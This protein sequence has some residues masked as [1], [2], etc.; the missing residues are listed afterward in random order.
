M[1]KSQE[2]DGKMNCLSTEW[3]REVYEAMY[4]DVARCMSDLKWKSDTVDK[5]LKDIVILAANARTHLDFDQDE[6]KAKTECCNVFSDYLMFCACI[7]LD[8]EGMIN[9]DVF[10]GPCGDFFKRAFRNAKVRV[11][12]LSDDLVCWPDV[13]HR[14]TLDLMSE[15]IRIHEEVIW[16]GNTVENVYML[17]DRIFDFLAYMFGNV[18]DFVSA[19]DKWRGA[20]GPSQT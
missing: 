3:F 13:F 18:E 6:T 19:F 20:Y 10:I 14:I 12:R 17:T 5:L 9:R 2:T 8:V 1:K 15:A 11:K 16:A 4:P 7:G